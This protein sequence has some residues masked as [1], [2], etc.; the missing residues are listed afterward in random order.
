MG[1]QLLSHARAQF[2]YSA[3]FVHAGRYVDAF[4]TSFPD[5]SLDRSLVVPIICGLN[6]DGY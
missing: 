1:T 4:V 2:E 6:R 3:N 5:H